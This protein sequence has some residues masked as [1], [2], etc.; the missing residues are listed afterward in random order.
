M[1]NCLHLHISMML[2]ISEQDK[3]LALV[4]GGLVHTG[5]GG[6][7]PRLGCALATSLVTFSVPRTTQTCS[8]LLLFFSKLI[9]INSITPTSPLQMCQHHQ[10]YNTMCLCVSIFTTIFKGLVT[11]FTTPLDPSNDA[12]LDHSSG[13]RWPICKQVCPSW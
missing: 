3:S 7:T 5:K 1:L 2:I 8:F 13:T 10:V 11:Q 4:L 6:A 9:Q 12:K